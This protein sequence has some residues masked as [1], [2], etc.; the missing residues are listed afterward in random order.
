MYITDGIHANEDIV[1]K[2][3]PRQ[4]RVKYAN[5]IIIGHTCHL[6]HTYIILK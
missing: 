2:E 3:S 5:V 6:M 1:I 4:A